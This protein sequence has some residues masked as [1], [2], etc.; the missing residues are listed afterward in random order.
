M[1]KSTILL[2]ML[3]AVQSMPYNSL[4]SDT[5]LEKVLSGL[6]DVAASGGHP[7][8]DLNKVTFPADAHVVSKAYPSSEFIVQICKELE[9]TDSVCKT[10]SAVCEYDTVSKA[11]SDVYAFA[12]TVTTAWVD[13]KLLMT[14]TGATCSADKDQHTQTKI[15]FICAAKDAGLRLVAESKFGCYVEFELAT[16]HACGGA[17]TTPPSSALYTCSEGTCHLSSTGVPRATCES[18]CD[19]PTHPPG[20]T[21]K[22]VDDDDDIEPVC[23]L[24]DSGTYPNKTSCDQKCAPTFICR[25]GECTAVLDGSGGSL[26]YCMMECKGPVEDEYKC[27]GGRCELTLEGGVSKELCEA[28]CGEAQN[29]TYKCEANQC[30]PKPEG[31]GVS[32]EVCKS[33]CEEV[34]TVAT[35]TVP[36]T[37]YICVDSVCQISETPGKGIS[38]ADCMVVCEVKPAFMYMKEE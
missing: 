37:T 38:K 32:K 23:V 4:T 22:C 28:V 34:T 26:D 5:A 16:T 3:A 20:S 35:T 29:K 27:A 15:S 21:F 17:E 6:C 25:E 19:G 7:A 31:G 14:M 10:G 2:G 8:M 18:I 30:K 13:D 33:I 1:M 36:E 11:T 24:D 9:F 12:D